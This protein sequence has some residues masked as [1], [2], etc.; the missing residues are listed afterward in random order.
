MA[1][2]SHF[3]SG[4]RSMNRLTKLD[5]QHKSHRDFEIPDQ[6]RHLV[7]ATDCLELLKSLP[8][9]SVQLILIDPPYNID[10]AEWD[11]YQNYVEWASDW[12]RES[13]RVLK[14]S[15]SFVIFGGIQY[16]NPRSGD[17]L[18]LMHH[19]RHHS[20]MKLV[21]LIV[22]T[23][24]NGMSASRLTKKRKRNTARTNG[25][26]RRALK[27]GRTQP[28]SGRSIDSTGTRRNVSAT[29]RKS[30][31]QSWSDSSNRLVIRGMSCWISLPGRASRQRSASRRVRNDALH[32][33]A[34][35]SS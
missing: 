17:L 28:T 27:K 3:N 11:T 22:W 34:S 12:I 14:E 15:G 6:T 31:L 1:N 35:V 26:T 8:D 33:T 32:R 13:E 25:S 19:I 4:H 29:L 5:K 24:Q 9:Q 10:M 2:R 18:E 7:A 20:S 23:Y 30:L 16:E 21:N